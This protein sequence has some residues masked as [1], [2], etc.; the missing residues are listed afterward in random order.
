LADHSS[1]KYSFD[2]FSHKKPVLIKATWTDFGLLT[3]PF[4]LYPP[5]SS[6]KITLLRLIAKVM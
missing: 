3:D 2:C 5:W 4:F 1:G 6:F